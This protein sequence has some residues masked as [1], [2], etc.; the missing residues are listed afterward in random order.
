VCASR[1]HARRQPSREITLF[2]KRVR[3]RLPRPAIRAGVVYVTEDRKREGFFEHMSIADN[4]YTNYLGAGLQAHGVVSLKETKVLA[5]HWTK[6]LQVKA[7]DSS[8][9]VIELSGGNQQKVVIAAAL[10]K[11][12]QL[13]IFDEPTRGV[14]VGAIADIHQLIRQL[15]GSGTGVVVISSYLPEILNLSDRILVARNGRIVEEFSAK[16]ANEE[17][18][19]FAAVH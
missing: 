9:S 11:R 13:I 19:M 2:E 5:E 1:C 16:E 18:I 6:A 17:D 14:D 4:V 10:V 15:A 12:P 3:Y 8:A 7:L